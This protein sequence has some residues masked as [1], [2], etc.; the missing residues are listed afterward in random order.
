MDNTIMT[1]TV[2][3]AEIDVERTDRKYERQKA[4]LYLAYYEMLKKKNVEK[5]GDD[6]HV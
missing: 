3:D 1:F 5:K 4:D 2:N 6:Y